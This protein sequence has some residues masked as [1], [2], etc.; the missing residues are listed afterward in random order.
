VGR[1]NRVT[2]VIAPFRSASLEAAAGKNPISHVGKLY[3]V[4][5]LL[6]ARDIVEKVPAVGEIQIYILSQI[7]KPL[8][9]PLVASASVTTADGSLSAGDRDAVEAILNEHLA[10]FNGLR[11]KILNM[12]VTPY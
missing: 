3:N 2:G 8:D 5:A 4:L 12:E 9:E 1:G 11:A 10:D 6:A 7:G